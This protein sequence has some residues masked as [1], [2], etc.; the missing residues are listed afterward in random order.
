MTALQSGNPAMRVL[1]RWDEAALN[2]DARP[3]AMTIGG[4]VTATAI[5]L[6]IVGAV[7][8]LVFQQLTQTAR[9]S[10]STTGS[11]AFP[12]WAW[13]ALIGG[14]IGGLAF[15]LIIAFK[16]KTAPFLAPIHA[17]LE[18]VFVG[19]LSFIIPAQFL[20]GE[21]AL[22]G[23]A[24]TLVIQAMLA[25]FGIC[26]AMLLGYASGVLR[27]GGF[28]KKMIITLSAG[29]MI[30]V[31]LLWILSMFGVGI[32]NGFADTGMLGIGFTGVCLGLASLYLLLDFEFIEQGVKA[33][34]P[35]YMEWVGAWGLM[36]TLVWVYIEVLRLLS[37]LR[38]ND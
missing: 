11:I 2:A 29:L 24:T 23:E 30:Y 14:M 38:S 28:A 31:A 20:G 1:E 35:K 7:G 10:L 34:A 9:A 16:P 12:A 32:W 22:G 37:K 8:V 13:P 6:A 3:K 27:L 33:G 21:K 26:A 4:T 5:L 15:S 25:T 17:G 36:V 19:A 18:G